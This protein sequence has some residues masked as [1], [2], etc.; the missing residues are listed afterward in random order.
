M[1]GGTL[2]VIP[3]FNEAATILRLVDAVFGVVPEAHV[4][5]VDD[6]SPDGTG[7]VVER[8]LGS[9]RRLHL[10]RRGA[11][12]GLGSAYVL[13]LG[14]G[15]SRDYGCFVQMDAD[16]SHDPSHLPAL[17]AALEAGADVACGSRNVRG[18]GVVGWGPGRHLLS[19][20]GSLYSR[21]ILSS[22]V[23]DMTTGYK[24]F[25]RRALEEIALGSVT[26]NGYAFQIETTFRAQRRGLRLVEVPIWFVDRRVGQSKMTYR[27]VAEAVVAVWRLRLRHR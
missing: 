13:G 18:G 14:W 19:K 3:T 8:R 7:Q 15:L 9:E 10:L 22:P 26:S 27:E 1:P 23:R 5:V 11:K 6:A 12:L 21:W 20:G 25:T 16:F 2:V 17:L 4:L 24:A